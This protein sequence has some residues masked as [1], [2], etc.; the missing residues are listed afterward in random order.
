MGKYVN[1]GNDGFRA[2][3][4]GT[5]VDKTGLISVMNKT[6]DTPDS[7]ICVSRPRRFGKSY[8]A[9]MLCAY[10]DKS[11]DSRALFENLEIS[12]D[13][14]FERHLNKHNVIFLDTTCFISMA[15]DINSFVDIMEKEVNSEV[16]ESFP[17]AEKADKLFITLFNIAEATGEKFIMIIDEWD[18]IFREAKENT[19]LQKEYITFLRGLFKTSLTCRTFCGVYITGILPIKKYGTQ[20]ALTDFREYTMLAPRKMAEY[21]GFTEPEVKGLCR[22]SGMPFDDMKAWYD[23]YSFGRAESVY[24]PNSV[25]QAISNGDVG[26][27]WT[28]TETYRSLQ[29]FI[30]MNE[31]GL[32]EAVIEMLGGKQVRISTI[33]FQNDLTDIKGRDDVLTLLVHLGYLAYNSKKETVY[34][35][36]REVKEEF[37]AAVS[38]GKHTEA[39]KLI[40]NSDRLLEATL[41]MDE[42]KVASIIEE[43]HKS[44]TAP[45]FYNNEQ[46][47]RSVIKL[48]YISSVDK[49][50]K[51]EELPSG[52]GCADVVFLPKKSSA[53]PMLLVEL[54]WNRSAEGAIAQIV[55]NDYPHAV[56][57]YGG[58]IL[59]V[60]INYD[61]KEKKHTCRIEKIRR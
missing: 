40:Q 48:A 8:A 2:I 43:A 34:I 57:D 45:I 52:R 24:S 10:Y 35:P 61:E 12:K 18:A 19:A 31:D 38:T 16:S 46:A 29:F 47:L 6:L 51:I 17:E 56:K 14:T 50:L 9:K 36:N 30:D 53:L 33:S 21:V 32:K 41:S 28:Q 27:Y 55:K 39:A 54:K 49:F 25:M 42:E 13:N 1:V 22:Q 11:C 44:G 26:N 60:G 37:I 59:L 7:L 3:R 58:D 23:G 15:S 4:N 5:Y 20:S